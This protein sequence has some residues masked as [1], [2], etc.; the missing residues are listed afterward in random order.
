MSLLSFQPLQLQYRVQGRMTENHQNRPSDASTVIDRLDRLD[1][2]AF[3]KSG[4]FT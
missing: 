4:K 2:K 1:E 3:K